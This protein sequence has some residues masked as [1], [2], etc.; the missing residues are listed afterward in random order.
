MAE[1]GGGYASGATS[2]KESVEMYRAEHRRE[3]ESKEAANEIRMKEH[4]AAHALQHMMTTEA[5]RERQDKLDIRLAG[6]NELRGALSDLSAKMSTKEY[7]DARI[8]ALISRIETLGHTLSDKLDASGKSDSER[9]KKIEE[10]M[11]AQRGTRG[12]SAATISY[13]MMAIG[14]A[15]SILAL[16]SFFAK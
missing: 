12:G 6:M 15:L 5:D 16:Y 13:I 1:E 8:E 4:A 11:A 2:L 10:E 3:H 7:V 9:L 14:A